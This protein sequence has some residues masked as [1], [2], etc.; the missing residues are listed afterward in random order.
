MTFLSPGFTGGTDSPQSPEHSKVTCIVRRGAKPG[1]MRELGYSQHPSLAY[2][3]GTLPPQRHALNTCI[4]I[5]PRSHHKGVERY[6]GEQK[7]C[8][9]SS[10]LGGEG[11]LKAGAPPPVLLKRCQCWNMQLSEGQQWMISQLG[12][13]QCPAMDRLYSSIC[14]LRWQGLFRS[15]ALHLCHACRRA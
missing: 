10:I 3:L 9:R 11:T 13:E 2:E 4:P 6:R 14:S 8:I 12:T 7:G 1:G 5:L 15:P